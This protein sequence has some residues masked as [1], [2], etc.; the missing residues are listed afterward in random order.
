[1]T[2]EQISRIKKLVGMHLQTAALPDDL[3]KKMLAMQNDALVEELMA[4]IRKRVES[5]S[6]MFVRRVAVNRARTPEETL[7]ATGR[8]IEIPDTVY[9]ENMR[10]LQR[11]PRGKE[12]EVDVHFFTVNHYSNFSSP[13][14]DKEYALRCLKPADPYSLAAAIEADP[15][16]FDRQEVG[17]HWKMHLSS[18]GFMKFYSRDG[19]GYLKM[20]CL[21]GGSLWSPNS[22]WFAGVRK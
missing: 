5:V 19:V 14:L 11:I 17:T 6:N 10:F 21:M 2:T 4:I 12:V 7:N 16:F 22:C 20:D 8:K 9:L 13:E 18:W 1:M 3:I 15:L